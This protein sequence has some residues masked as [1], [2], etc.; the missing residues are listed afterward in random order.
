M[1]QVT[2]ADATGRVVLPALVAVGYAAYSFYEYGRQN[3]NAGILL[4]GGVLALLA[5]GPATYFRPPPPSMRWLPTV[6]SAICY[7][8]AGYLFLIIGF[9]ALGLALSERSSWIVARFTGSWLSSKKPA[10]NSRK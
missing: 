7:L 2:Q 9:L 3:T 1:N 6:T 8:F 4:I 10:S 5:S